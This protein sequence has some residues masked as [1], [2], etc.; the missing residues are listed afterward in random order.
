MR[1]A[2][3]T[4]FHLRMAALVIGSLF[5][6]HL[7]ATRLPNWSSPAIGIV[8]FVLGLA[9]VALFAFHHGRALQDRLRVLEDRLDR[10]TQRVDAG[11][12]AQRARRALPPL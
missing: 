4:A 2:N 5:L 9:W 10:L 11:E 8:T 12:D 1:F 6:E 3:D 7:A